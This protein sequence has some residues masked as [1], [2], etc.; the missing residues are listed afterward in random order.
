MHGAVENMEVLKATNILLQETAR[1]LRATANPWGFGNQLSNIRLTE[2]KRDD[3]KSMLDDTNAHSRLMH[4]S[5]H[6]EAQRLPRLEIFNILL[7]SYFHNFHAQHPI[8]HLP[9]II[10][11][12]GHPGGLE[13]KKDILLYAMCC[14]GAFRHA[15]R[16]IQE[17]AR[18]MQELLRRT[19]SYHFEKDPRHIRDL[20][21]MQAWHLCLFIGGWSGSARASESSQAFCGALNSMLRCGHY[22]DG[23][24][25]D[26]YEED[27]RPVA[28]GEE[29][30]RW[31]MFVEC[32]E[33][34]RL[35][36]SQLW[37]EC[38]MGSFMRVRPTMTYSELTLPVMCEMELWRA[39]TA[40]DWAKLWNHNLNT[41][42][43]RGDHELFEPSVIGA[44][45]QFAKL[46]SDFTTV[47]HVARQIEYGRHLPSLLMGIHSLVVTISENRS[48]V[49]WD[50]RAINAGVSECNTM[51]NYWWAVR[52]ACHGTTAAPVTTEWL[53]FSSNDINVDCAPDFLQ[54]LDITAVL[55]HFTAMMLHIPLREIRLMNE[56]NYLPIRK[57]AATRLW[58]S[59]KDTNRGENARLGLWHAGQIIRYARIMINNDTGPLWLA[60]MVAEAANVMWSYAALIRYDDQI[61]R[62][63][64]L[65]GEYLPLD[66]DDKWNDIPVSARNHGVPSI[67]N[68]QGEVI[69]LTN[70]RAVVTEC[71]EMLNRGPLGKKS[72]HARG[73]TILDEQFIT[74]LDKLVKFGNIE[75]LIAGLQESSVKK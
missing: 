74:Q 28:P 1:K 73:K 8:F 55:F 15:A 60:P 70:A 62:G 24:R 30:E 52:E 61:Q 14:A 40:E 46:S 42:L 59:W 50:S 39:E 68:R 36:F 17:Y 32:E 58:R 65:N 5:E 64:A 66:S 4:P 18:G 13:K 69:P 20:Q 31:R 34:K 27:L 54:S 35:I 63:K 53:E 44:L 43:P 29:T 57:M 10:P 6:A 2:D 25:G 23:Q 22:F 26:W 47:A 49:H 9:S 7:K 16:P 51:L 75:F 12:D 72:K 41:R 19:I 11:R 37:F 48:C 67:T 56:R 71:A 3:I 33:K 38:H 45:R 21:S